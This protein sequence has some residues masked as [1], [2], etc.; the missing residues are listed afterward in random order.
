MKFSNADE[1]KIQLAKDIRVAET[2]GRE[3]LTQN[4]A[5]M[6]KFGTLPL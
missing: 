1:L 4:K 6:N 2:A 5:I 3:Y